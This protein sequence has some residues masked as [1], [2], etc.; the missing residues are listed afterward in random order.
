MQTMIF[1]LEMKNI[2]NEIK[3]N[4]GTNEGERWS[5]GG[6]YS[7]SPPSTTSKLINS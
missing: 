6:N 1:N 5:H 7:R 4:G 2:Y 3:S